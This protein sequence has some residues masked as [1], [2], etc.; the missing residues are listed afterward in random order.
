MAWNGCSGVVM[1]QELV[2]QVYLWHR[3][4]LLRCVMAE[5]Q[6]MQMCY[7]TGTGCSGMIWHRKWLFRC[8]V[9][10]NGCSGVMAQELVAQVC[11]GTQTQ[12]ADVLWHRN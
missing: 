12:Y 6:G 4:R 3:N 8:F 7:G 2:V 1:A 5:K 11:Y 9:A 10:W